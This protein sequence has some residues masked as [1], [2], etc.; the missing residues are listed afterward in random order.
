MIGEAD[1]EKVASAGKVLTAKRRPRPAWRKWVRLAACLCLIAGLAVS[2]LRLKDL[3]Q[4]SKVPSLDVIEY[5]GAYYEVIDTTRRKVL[6]NYNLPHEI[7]AEMVG[8][9]LG[10]GLGPGPDG[11]RAERVLY[12]YAPY[13]DITASAGGEE[14]PQGAVYVV[15]KEGGYAFA[16][17]CNFVGPAREAHQAAAEMFAVYGVDQAADIQSVTIGR[18]TVTDPVKI[19]EIFDALLAAPAAGNDGFQEAVFNGLSEAEQ[20][21][22]SHELADD[23]KEMQFLT[24]AGIVIRGLAYYPS[25]R[26]VEWAVND[27]WLEKPLV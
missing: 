10:T 14:R 24:E 17:F 11:E 22:L 6:E 15:K 18:E 13:G 1:P 23:R 16:L 25:F 21:A 26:Y 4:D 8:P 5:G 2:A 12:Q 3:T 9:A 20:Q 27:Y 7:T 19:G